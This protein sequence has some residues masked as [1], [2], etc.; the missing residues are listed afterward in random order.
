MKIKNNEKSNGMKKPKLIERRTEGNKIECFNRKG[1][2]F[3]C[4]L[5]YIVSVI[6]VA[7]FVFFSS[8]SLLFHL[9][10]E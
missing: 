1:N 10:L 5:K 3:R 8:S 7:V 9:L 2:A 6:V 4:M